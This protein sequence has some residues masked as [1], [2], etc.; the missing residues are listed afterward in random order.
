VTKK[1]NADTTSIAKA[2]EREDEK[3]NLDE[4]RSV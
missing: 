1:Q 4:I 2:A 3:P